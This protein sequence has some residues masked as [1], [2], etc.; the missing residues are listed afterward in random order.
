MC[1]N[2]KNLISTDSI[3]IDTFFPRNYDLA[4]SVDFEDF[5]EEF[6]F[7]KVFFIII[8]YNYLKKAYDILKY[9]F[10]KVE[11]NQ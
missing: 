1:R 7:S 6:K 4:D 9:Y 11:N 3:D 8:I 10:N 5:I 2:L